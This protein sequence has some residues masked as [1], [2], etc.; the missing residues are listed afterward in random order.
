VKLSDD[1]IVYKLKK[2]AYRLKQQYKKIGLCLKGIFYKIS[3]FYYNRKWQKDVFYIFI[4]RLFDYTR[5]DSHFLE[6]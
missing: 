2:P 6:T 1:H 3:T 4:Y 5:N